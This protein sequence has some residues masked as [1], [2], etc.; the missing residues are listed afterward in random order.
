MQPC[1]S[2]AMYMPGDTIHDAATEPHT[3]MLPAHRASK[4]AVDES[5]NNLSAAEELPAAAAKELVSTSPVARETEAS[6]EEKT[7]CMSEYY[8]NKV[9]AE[10]CRDL[11]QTAFP[12]KVTA[13]LSHQRFQ[14]LVFTTCT[15]TME[16]SKWL[17]AGTTT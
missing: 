8:R 13:P 5:V 7:D 16:L 17:L 9:P 11:L 4:A 2:Q 10:Q 14:F 3:N 1:L 12:T 6:V 15:A